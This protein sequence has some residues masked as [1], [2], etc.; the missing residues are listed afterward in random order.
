MYKDM[1][2]MHAGHLTTALRI[3][4]HYKTALEEIEQFGYKNSGSGY[5][6]A[7]MATEALGKPAKKRK[8]T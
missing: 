3:I 6:C 4:A 7:A 1:T 2:Y 5:S 8:R